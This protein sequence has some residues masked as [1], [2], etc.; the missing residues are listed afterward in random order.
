[1]QFRLPALRERGDDVLMLAEHFLQVFAAQMNRSARKLSATAKQKLLS[2]HWPGI[3]RE[4]RNVIERALILE[5]SAEIQ[6]VSLPDFQIEGRLRT[7]ETAAPVGGSLDEIIAN[8]E[9]D[10]IASML[11]RNNRSIGKTAEQLK[12]SRHALRY[13]MQRLNLSQAD[14]DDST[15]EIRP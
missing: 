10:L 3:V 7:G 13:R 6:A 14:V 1:M 2:H 11:E 5:P 9:R 15:A 8:Y 12:L 4:L